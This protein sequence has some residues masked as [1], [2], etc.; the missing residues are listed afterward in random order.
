[1]PTVLA[2]AEP[3]DSSMHDL[4]RAWLPALPRRFYAHLTEGVADALTGEY[5]LQAHGT[6]HKMGLTDRS[7]VAA[8]SGFEA[9]ALTASDMDELLALYAASYPGNWFVPRML[10]TGCYFGIRSGGALVCVAGVHVYSPH[11]KVAALGNVTTR[12]DARGQ[13]L[14]TAATAKLCQSLLQAGIEH[15]G[16]NVKADN[17][18]AVAC[19]KKLGFERI[20]DYGEYTVVE[21][22]RQ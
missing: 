8:F 5:H 19:Y 7:R 17:H 20:A 15:V 21:S 11:H 16:L 1:M 14:A 9:V 18:P 22:A 13:G 2:V 12:P 3:H 6:F 4:L 10:Q